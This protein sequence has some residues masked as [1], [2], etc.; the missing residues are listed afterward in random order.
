MIESKAIP[1]LFEEAVEFT[2]LAGNLAQVDELRHDPFSRFRVRQSYKLKGCA[3]KPVN[4]SL[5]EALTC[6]VSK[7][8]QSRPVD[9]S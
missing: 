7:L 4:A 2:G 9:R 1:H 5:K 3:L 8:W 6:N